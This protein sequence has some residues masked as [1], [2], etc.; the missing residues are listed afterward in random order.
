MQANAAT[1]N[2]KTVVDPDTINDWALMTDGSPSTQNVGRIWTDKSVFNDTYTFSGSADL[3]GKTI[4][5]GDS[6]FLVGL[7][8]LS[9]TSNLKEMVK[10]SKPL[11]IVL[12]LDT[13]GSMSGS[14]MTNLKNA[15]NRF[16]DAT[17]ENNRGLEQNQQTRLAIV[18]FASGANTRQN[19]NY[20]TDQN[21][22]QYKN[23]I[24]SFSANGATYAEEGLQQAQNVLDRN[25]RPD[26]QQ[27]VIF[28]T[29]GE[30]NH[31]SGF[32]NE[33]A[34]EAVN[35]AHDMKQGGT[36]IYAIGVMNGADASVTDDD[37]FNEYMNGVSSNYPDATADGYNGFFGWGAYYNT[38]FGDRAEGDYYKAA[39]DP[40]S[41]E[42]IFDEISDE[43]QQGFGSGSPIV[44]ESEEG[45]TDPGT[46]TFTD[47]L[48]AYMQVTGTG[49]GND[50]IQL[51]Y[52]DTI[53]TSD[54][55]TT[56]GNTD[57]Y[58]FS[59]Q[60]EG[61][62]VYG[63][64]NLADL[65]VTVERSNDPAVGDKV[66]VQLPA[67]LLP[68][69][70][71]DVDTDNH[72]MT[73]AEAYPVR[74][75]YGVSL[76]AAAEEALS[77]PTSDV[78]A[79]IMGSQKSEDGKTVDF[80]TNS[81]VKGAAD[82]SA[83]ASFE[84]NA[85]NKFYYYT[86][87]TPLYID[88]DC[89]TKA[90]EWN[91]R[92]ADT[93]YWKDTYW[94]QTQGGGAEEHTTG[95]A[96]NRGT[97][98]WEAMESTGGY[99]GTYYIPAGTPRSDRPATLTSAKT[100]NVTGT[101]TNVLN[102][103]WA[104]TS[105]NQHLG[106]NGKLS[107]D[108]PGSLEIKKTVDW[109]NA[110]DQTKQDKNS[111]TFK[112]SLTDEEGTALT[113]EYPYYIDGASDQ[114]GTVEN[115]GTITI[116]GGQSVKIEGLPAGTQFTVE[117][118]GANTNGFT[119]TDAST[120]AGNDNTNDGTVAGEI[121]GGGNVSTTFTNTY[122]AE[123]VNLSTSTTLKVKKDLQDRDWRD[124]DEFTFEIDGLGNTAGPGITTPEPADTT[125][126]VNSQTTDYT[127]SFGDI[128]FTAP[129]E[130]R[131][132]IT[133]DNDTNPIAGI[134]YSGAIYRVV[135]TVTDNGTGNLEVSN[136]AIEQ[137]TNDDGV[138][139]NPAVAVQGD[140]VTFV[141]KYDADGGTTN[142]DGTKS[143]TDT[144][145]G[146]PID[147]DKFTFKIEALGGY[148]TD[149]P[150]TSPYT[151]GVDETPLPAGSDEATHS[152]TVYNTGYDF[153]F[154][155]IAFDG[156]DIGRTY[157]YKVTE[158]AQNKDGQAEDGMTYDTKEYT[159][160]VAVTEVTDDN[161]THIVAT[162]DIAPKDL[163]FTNVYK[164]TDVTLG[165]NGVAPIQGTKTL[166]GRDMKDGETFYFQLTQTGGP[167]V[168][169]GGFVTVLK[170]PETVTVS[171]N[172]MQ[173]GSADFKFSNLTFSQ[174]GTY[175]FTVNE[176]ADEQGTETANGSGMTY[177]TNVAE[178]TVVVSDNHDGT[179][180]AEVTYQN[181]KH[182]DTTDK[183]LFA[184]T[185]EAS[186]NYGAEG[187]GGINVTK[188]MLDRPMANNEFSFTIAGT[189]SD[190]VKADEAN[191]KLADV[192]KSF[193]NTAAAENGTDTMTKLQNVSF[194]QDDAGKTFSYLVSETVPADGDKLPNV[195]YDQSQYR[196][197]IEVVDNGDGT[198]HT[199]TTVTKVKA[200]DGT[201]V[202]EVV[203][204][205]ANSDAQDYA[206]P[207]FGFVNDYNPN[208]ATVGENADHEIQVTKKVEGA[209][210]ATD[211]TFTLTATGNNVGNIEGLDQNNQLTVNTDG[212][213]K[214]GES[215]TKTFGALTF[216]EPGTYT[217]TVQ[218]N[219]PDKDA[220]WTFDDADGDG[221]TDAHTVTVYVTDRNEDGQ[222]D[223][224]LY[225]D[226]VT[227]SPVEIT[228][229]Y[230]A[231]SVVVGGDG[232]QQ[233]ITVQKTVTGADSA[234]DFQ[235]K[236]EP[237]DPDNDKWKNVEAVDEDFD[238]LTSITD[239]F[240]D[241]DSKTATFGG[242]KFNATGEYQFKITEV[243]AAEFN[244]GTTEERAGWTYDEHE[245]IVTVKVTDDNFDGQLDA[246]VTYEN[247]AQ[248]AEF[249]N[250]YEAG[251]TTL[252]G[253]KS[254]K[255]TK[256]IEG[257]NGIADETFGF[258]LAKGTVA[259]G[260]SWDAVTFQPT[261]AEA[262]AFGTARATAT[263]NG[264][265]SA[266]FWFDG[267]FTFA[268]AGTYTFNVTETSHNGNDLPADGTNGMTY[269]CHTGTITVKVTDD[270]KGNLHAEAVAGNITEGDTENDLT[271][272]NVYASEPARWGLAESELLGGHKYI[273]DT[274]GNTYTLE[275]DQFS[276][277]LRAQA[278]GNPMPE[279][280]DNTTD[281][282]GRGM[283]TVTNGT[284]N[285]TDVSIYD[286]GWIEFTHDDM[287]GAT[288]VEDK[289]G[290]F[291]KTFQYNIFE[292]GIMP[293]GISRDN[294]AYTVTFTVTEDHNTGKITVATPTAVKIVN[295]G[296]GE[297]T[298]GDPV[299]VTKLDF[300]NTYD[301]TTINGHQN[302]FKTL[303]GRNWQQGDTFTFD[304]SMTATQVDGSKWPAGAPLPS[305][306]PSDGY[307]FSEIK[308]NDAGNGLD[309]TV[310]INPESQTHNTYRFDTGTI[311][312]EREGVYTWV[313]SE[314]QS[315][316]D[317]VT[318]DDAKYTV[319]VT[320]TDENGVLKRS[321]KVINGDSVEVDGD[322]TLDFTNVYKPE[323][324]STDDPNGIGNIQVT[325]KV[326]GNA[327]DAAFNFTL[328]LTSGNAANVL[329][330]A[331]D[332]KSAFPVDG[333]T[334]TSEAGFTDGQTK[335]VDFGALT[336]TAAGDYTF[337]VE[338]TDDA[339]ANWTY[340]NGDANAKTVTIHVTD[341]DNNGELV[342]SYDQDAPN[343]PMFTNSYKADGSLDGDA[344]GAKNLMVTKTIDNRKFQE[345]DT[346]TFQL[347][348]DE[349]NPVG[350]VLPDNAN[351][352][353]IA[354]ADGDDTFS[355]SAA[356]GDITFTLPGTYEFHVSEVAP[357]EEDKLGG[358]TYSDE[359]YTVTVKVTDAQDGNGKL[360]AEITKI[361]NKAG[362][363]VD[364]LAFTN[365]YKAG[366]STDLPATGE[367]SIQLQKVLTGKAWNDD[368]NGDKFTFQLTAVGATADDGSKIDTV[369]MPDDDKVTVS[370]KT[371][372]NKDGNDYAD[373][374]FGPITYNQA[375][376]YIYEV[377][378]VPGDNGGITYDDHKA[379]V[380]VSVV[381]NLHGGFAATAS[382]KDGTFT[383]QYASELDFAAAG[384]VEIVK[385]FENADM[386]E[387][388][389]T[390][391]PKDQA[392]A[393]K[394]GIDMAGETF[395]TN[396][397]ANIGDDNASHAEIM[398]ID[399][400]TE[401]K[402]T[403]DDADDTY[404]YTVQETKGTD[405]SVDYDGTVYTVIITTADDGQGGIKVTTKVTDGADYNETYVYDNDEATAD[406]TVVI[407]F[408][409]TYK[410][411]GDLGGN[412]STSIKATKQLTNRPMTAGEFKFNVT[413]AADTD[414]KVV[415]TGTNAADGTI[416][417][418]DINYSI[419]Q[420][421]D[422]V[423]NGLAIP[424]V[425]D[426]KDTFTYQYTVTEDHESFDDGVTAIADSFSI[427][428]TVTDNGDGTLGIAVAYPDGADGLTFRN[429]YGEG[430]QGQA[431]MS[432]VGQKKLYVESGNNAP[433]ITGKYTF[434]LTGSDGAPMPDKT[435]ATND[436]AGNVTFGD[437]TYTM[438]NVF[439]DTGV[440][441]D[442][443]EEEAAETATG[444]A[445]DTAGAADEADVD[446]QSA[447]R[448][449]TFTYTVTESGT[450][451]GV[452][453]DA[454]ASK[455]FTV[456]VTDNG[457][458]TL[459]AVSDP[460]QGAKFS[461]TNTYSVDSKD[462]SVTG[463]GNLT[464]TK[465]LTGRDLAEGEFKVVMTD[466]NNKEVA[467]GTNDAQGNIA[468]SA[469][470]FT[471]PGDYTY[472]LYE[473][474]GDKGGVTYDNARY[475]A[476]AHVKDK[477]N[478]ML[479]VTWSVKNAAGEAV[480]AI[481]IH[482]TYAA[483][484]TS[485]KLGGTKVLD[486]RELNE[487]EFTFVLTD[488]NGN[489]LQKVTNSAQG[490]FCFDT[491][492]YDA[493]GTYEYTI[494]EAKGDVA[495]VTYDEATFAVKVVVT[496]DGT[497]Q[498][499]VT[500]LTY[501]GKA[502]LPVFTNSYVEPAQPAAPA[503]E[504]TDVLPQTGDKTPLALVGVIAA[505]ALAAL[506]VA[507]VK[508]RRSSRSHHM[509]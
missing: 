477:G 70:N 312:Y 56:S 292:T 373:F 506:V 475:L 52:G 375:G 138:E 408:A 361:M 457:D 425:V 164:P 15:A 131:Y 487:G 311:T 385:T 104:G 305:V 208:P 139:N 382:V 463:D 233:Q 215:Q 78:Y 335:T 435:T 72:T 273:N 381:D 291:T 428:V 222:Y 125:I 135:I 229:S 257:R 490:G 152:K 353:T 271:F 366:G 386:R 383:N 73:V 151:Y 162:P 98:E 121:V 108:M 410:A 221:A 328:T 330:N 83:T 372:T 470:T 249:T 258:E 48:G 43:V 199:V 232:A 402:F 149:N 145:G 412:G 158:L 30:P 137:R 449:K 496:D 480:D 224:N 92:G 84:P 473:A 71:Y 248:A 133:E 329:T 130:Y 7:S 387:F 399:P 188:Q 464:I 434:T 414:N 437:I 430:D 397:G 8:A 424:S 165:E 337:K 16:I 307:D 118:Q 395:T 465:E 322:Q 295:G 368:E 376:T 500:E 350:A 45:N 275:A 446:V 367:G 460:A 86:Q 509:R 154:G 462:S 394:L 200:L 68:L 253:S 168:D 182:A 180:K 216:T 299:D 218:E 235:F 112:V 507:G 91:S 106:N 122:K 34:A 301:P 458:G 310:T 404:T 499:K 332:P 488:Q 365:T 355:K 82:G 67:S 341:P 268:Q 317:H 144:T 267:T 237:V 119:T 417:F 19:L 501:N 306:T 90:N 128:T 485:V 371:G 336:F 146:N 61:N 174:V 241:G 356:F 136:V 207:T 155:T 345:D 333:I 246:A 46:L 236:I 142:I 129:G 354:Y 79:A 107:L 256:I 440:Q 278:A 76:K 416:T 170:Q 181:D 277:T 20:V 374:G 461:F 193:Q 297:G 93:L 433:D 379:T 110:S 169:G 284:G 451:D 388:S 400:Q 184:N 436:A 426:G 489:E 242:I 230:K 243:G 454:K 431:T 141:N 502:E 201:E 153:T 359:Q 117:E 126:A 53:Y 63:A 478:G 124:T 22:Q 127:A 338:E 41:I 134:D 103:A 286:F 321:V 279:G 109:G 49:A 171:K 288:E 1:E 214:A 369:P 439:G 476:T 459:S 448:T 191:A 427:T 392:S 429:A 340:A 38:D 391:T 55:K 492:T 421:L 226:R 269:D 298:S 54:S 160:K 498:L 4:Q 47:Q 97:A 42:S 318:S 120:A 238:A 283:M 413:N 227:G 115:G 444:E 94:V 272:E 406:P 486:G 324:V 407:P 442:A 405:G 95:V 116:N 213:I 225:I 358:M 285:A 261:N 198:M 471:Q 65:V 441:A 111:F 250:K 494:A 339:P 203:V 81:F 344:E 105:V 505:L 469:I 432:I 482:N 303:E 262:A 316:V 195:A 186:M 467:S 357:A 62:A 177:D 479:E 491:I 148:D 255:G 33:V 323:D 251:S 172:N 21:A 348:A 319:E 176:V 300:T 247:G 447:Q 85:G 378:E 274:T 28:F 259:D 474:A 113:G 150:Q 270:G 327:T 349:D 231:D 40:D 326:E 220:G 114:T 3:D 31:Q 362:D 483:A 468:L 204:D 398:V 87:D 289:P 302:I 452:D 209:D 453:N 157:E 88:E 244:G 6:D 263:M 456:T 58:H 74:L 18:Q 280:W 11:D 100:D 346:F 296:S 23:T 264:G 347:T 60:V 380:T 351:G 493:A 192:D 240:G 281:G 183:A 202:S 99:D 396:P 308:T 276:F 64:A 309:Y 102:P 26:V 178:V 66:T 294:T 420:M 210:S 409:N 167:A 239:D 161:G 343:N 252:I 422:D 69:R 17:A 390:V 334:K 364:G 254:F 304:V 57:T 450:V 12:V 484:S 36:I 287:A 234:A 80:Y 77:D 325:K 51:A 342:A 75:F 156:G 377:T 466:Q 260:G 37:G 9:S 24:N 211:Y 331:D 290:V 503:D 194:D 217:F 89:T 32:D 282:Q 314:Q 132:N 393:D 443:A 219:Q 173:S 175:T 166:D 293:A 415:A 13:S 206:A 196:V 320:V 147:A 438:E 360:D 140:T 39:S 455:T 266:E 96:V 190:M 363:E 481:T 50:K 228:N 159:I 418:S 265:D 25:G 423:D 44:D 223:G 189:D 5:K 370:K 197:D 35:T 163:V 29:D 185:Y 245:A 187:E 508:M 352:L 101:A 179:L 411:T 504:P 389:F 472:N 445:A 59:G 205:H 403:Q 315:K 14:K 27:I 497:G 212:T 419:D 10:T 143:Y 495:G 384:G 313:V 123:D 2:A 401:A